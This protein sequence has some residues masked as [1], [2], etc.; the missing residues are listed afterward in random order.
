MS[1]L[2]LF[3]VAILGTL[4]SSGTV[5]SHAAG[6]SALRIRPSD[7]VGGYPTATGSGTVQPHD[8]VGGNPTHS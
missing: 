8:I 5:L 2:T 1:I 3:L 7:I 6:G 4:A